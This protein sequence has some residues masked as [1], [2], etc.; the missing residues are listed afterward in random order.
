MAS[1]QRLLSPLTGR[2]SYRVQ[3]RLRG[4]PSQS[5]TFRHRKDAERWASSLESGI[6]EG[7]YFPDAVARRTSFATLAERY[8]RSVLADARTE[9]RSNAQHHIAWW[10][11]RLGTLNLAEITPDHIAQGRD[12]LATQTYVRAEASQGKDGATAPAAYKRSGAT[13]NRYL[14]TLSHIFTTAMRE[15]RLIDRNPVAEVSKKKEARGRTRFLR[16]EE[17]DA[18]LMA[19]AE[20]AWPALHTLVLLADD[21]IPNLL[22]LSDTF[23]NRVELLGS[24]KGIDPKIFSRTFEVK[25]RG[26]TLNIVGREDFIAIKCFAGSAHDL[27]DARSAYQAAPG[28]IDLDLLRTVTRRFGRNAADRLE[29]VLAG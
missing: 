23:D 29:Q 19:C 4:H 6:R 14:A 26:V 11:G 25:L 15:W 3:V 2:I 18:L 9:R 5:G 21:P 20:S 7:R 22:V 8:A 16:D 28:P 24:L 10:L 27:L 17:R 1:I 12:A 13:V